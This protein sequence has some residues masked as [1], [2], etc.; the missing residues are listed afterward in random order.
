MVIA[1]EEG[2]SPPLASCMCPAPL[3]SVTNKPLATGHI[4]VAF[5]WKPR[6]RFKAEKWYLSWDRVQAP[7]FPAFMLR[8]WLL[9]NC[10]CW[11]ATAVTQGTLVL[12]TSGSSSAYKRTDCSYTVA[13]FMALSQ[14]SVPSCFQNFTTCIQEAESVSPPFASG[15]DFMTVLTDRRWQKWHHVTSGTRLEKVTWF[16]SGSF[17]GHFSWNPATV[18]WGSPGHTGDVSIWAKSLSLRSQRKASISN[19]Q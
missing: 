19:R 18:L 12:E 17:S 8:S 6:L 4:S 7:V 2:R 14:I 9:V 1:L 13:H 15:H 5:S 10:I 11:H 3:S 16:L